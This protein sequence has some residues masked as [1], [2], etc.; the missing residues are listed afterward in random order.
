MHA[1]CQIKHRTKSQLSSHRL[2]LQFTLKFLLRRWHSPFLSEGACD[3][4]N[5][6]IIIIAWAAKCGHL[7]LDIQLQFCARRRILAIPGCRCDTF[8]IEFRCWLINR[9]F[10]KPS[11]RRCDFIIVKIMKIWRHY[12]C[13]AHLLFTMFTMFSW[14]LYVIWKCFKPQR[15][16]SH[17]CCAK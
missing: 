4:S 14:R 6:L 13:S 1:H 17:K 2:K 3:A 10:S 5:P 15:A 12:Y 16:S 11:L 8:V 9:R 7:Q